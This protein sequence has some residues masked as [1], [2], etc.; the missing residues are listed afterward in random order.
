MK[1]YAEI[2]SIEIYLKKKRKEKEKRSFVNES[3]A[4]DRQAA[5]A[6]LPEMDTEIRQS[7][8]QRLPEANRITLL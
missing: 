3:S 6:C 1:K 5:N 2:F 7:E 4:A 8:A